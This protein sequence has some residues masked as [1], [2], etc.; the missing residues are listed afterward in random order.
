[1]PCFHLNLIGADV[2]RDEEGHELADL[3]TAIAIAIAGA[4][5]LIADLVVSG[6][7]A[8]LGQRIDI[9]DD[10]DVVLHTVHFAD[11]VRFVG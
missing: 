7:T 8:D 6:K 9:T 1:M 10:D 4:R 5:E 3:D 2:V 11:V